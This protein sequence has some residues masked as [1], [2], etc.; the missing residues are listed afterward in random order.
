MTSIIVLDAGPLWLAVQTQ[1]KKTA[2]A[3]RGKL[4]EW[5]DRVLRLSFP[6]S[7]ITKFVENWSVHEPPRH[8]GDLTPS[9][10]G[11]TFD[12]SIGYQGEWLPNSGRS[13]A[14]RACRPPIHTRWMPIA[15]SRRRRALSADRA[16]R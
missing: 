4:R 7:P 2:D 3:C 11:S 1:G 16:T 15:S 5:E 8:F 13:S 10:I 6:K 9:A 12:I 14:A